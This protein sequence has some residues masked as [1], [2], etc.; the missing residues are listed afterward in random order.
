VRQPVPRW[1]DFAQSISGAPAGVVD[2]SITPAEPSRMIIVARAL[3][4]ALK[5]ALEAAAL[6][7]LLALFFVRVP[8]I[9]GRSMEPQLRAE[10]HV[11]INTLAYDFRIGG[12]DRP[13]FDAKLQDIRRGD[14]IAFDHALDGIH[15]VYVKRVI[16]LPGDSIAIA[17]GIVSIDGAALRETSRVARDATN[18]PMLHVPAGAY[19]V[20]GD[21]R[22][23]SDDS[24]MFGAVP[25]AAVIGR[26]ALVVWPLNRAGPIR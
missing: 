24:R 15:R 20:L 18:M 23:D 13:L 21:N 2:L 25:R 5:L 9:A 6:L 4:R 22:G 14:V 12:G 16:G 17:N 10:E 8:Q 3:L 26:A 11:L 19:F 1:H 7:T